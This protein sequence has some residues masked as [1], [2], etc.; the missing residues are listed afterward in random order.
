MASFQA[1]SRRP[2]VHILGGKGK[3]KSSA[4]IEAHITKES[5]VFRTPFVNQFVIVLYLCSPVFLFP[6]PYE[7]R[8]TF[9]RDVDESTTR[10]LSSY[11]LFHIE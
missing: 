2:L 10:L 9:E 6:G 11:A 8:P 5:Y 7:I 3:G 1:F 4:M